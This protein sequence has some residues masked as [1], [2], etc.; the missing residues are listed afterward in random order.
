MLDV[1]RFNIT[2]DT[3]R[4][5]TDGEVFDYLYGNLTDDELNKDYVDVNLIA[6]PN[7]R[8]VVDAA[9]QKVYKTDSMRRWWLEANRN[10]P[11]LI[12]KTM[13]LM[14]QSVYA[15]R[16][17]LEKTRPYRKARGHLPSYQIAMLY[18]S[19]NEIRNKIDGLIN[20]MM[21]FHHTHK[22]FFY[23][24]VYERIVSANMDVEYIT[25]RMFQI[26]AKAQEIDEDDVQ[27]PP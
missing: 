7:M 13:D 27:K 5:L 6:D 23:V 22:F 20:T 19:L 8:P 24:L 1:L 3:K 2:A 26:N 4:N 16:Y 25:Q 11:F 21:K 14:K 12:N 18:S 17:R 10:D 15:T 9:I